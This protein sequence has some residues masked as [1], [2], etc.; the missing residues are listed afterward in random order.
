MTPKSLHNRST[1][2]KG[3]SM[4]AQARQL[5]AASSEPGPLVGRTQEKG[6][7]ASFLE[8]SL[9]NQTRR[10]LYI[11]G[12]PGTGKSALVREVCREFADRPG[13]KFVNVNCMSLKGS[14]DLGNK[15]CDELLADCD[16]TAQG[17]WATLQGLLGPNKKKVGDRF[18][19]I[20]DEI[21]HLLT[22]DTESLYSLFEWALHQSSR[23]TVIGIANALDLTDRFLPL[24]KAR[25]L[26][27]L[28]LPFLPYTHTQIVEVISQK[29]L[30][31]LPAN[32][33]QDDKNLP[34][35]QSAA[36]Q[37]CAKKVA[38]Q[39][40]DLRKAFDI[41]RRS[42]DIVELEAKE[43]S[44]VAPF[45]D[46]PSHR[47]KADQPSTTSDL[48]TTPA[49]ASKLL[50]IATAPRVTIAHVSRVSASA[51]SNGT[52]QRL[53]SLNLQQKAALCAL[54][55]HQKANTAGHDISPNSLL[56]TPTKKP[57]PTPSPPTL[58]KLHQTYSNLCRRENL[59]QP[60]TTTEFADVLGGLETLGLV[61][62]HN[63][64]NG[65]GLSLAQGAGTPSRSSEGRRFGGSGGAVAL[66]MEERRWVSF[67]NEK[68]ISGCLQGPGG[69][70]LRGLLSVVD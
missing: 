61:G 62:Q 64:N 44:A 7:L 8:G 31:L 34:L 39:S 70:I 28:L 22:F 11:S 33:P 58:R 25:N 55:S 59:L 5:F 52:P 3:P 24:L 6:N 1:A 4:F 10:S 48:S 30:S 40:G 32:E 35:F 54:V 20:M 17:S 37:L 36:L 14:S 68:E 45:E 41:V 2:G 23:L 63:N 56:F 50:T 47:P 51:F 29:L 49:S 15:L 43:R 16:E 21:D 53:K 69:E 65:R 66:A 60:L 27:P 12:P 42:L 57:S 18:V 19:V 67:A 38:S 26:K 13:V 46:S 9:N